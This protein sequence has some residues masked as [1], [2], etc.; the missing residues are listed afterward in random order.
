M[1]MKTGLVVLGVGAAVAGAVWYAF[2][3][4][5]YG[6]L[7]VREGR[8]TS[9]E[10]VPGHYRE[11]EPVDS[12]GRRDLTRP[13]TREWVRP[14]WTVRIAWEG[15]EHVVRTESLYSQVT[16]GSP[17]TLHVRERRWRGR[18]SG[19]SVQTVSPGAPAQAAV[20]AP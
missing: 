16:V 6:P 20:P 15:G 10:H 9:A 17:V 7:E 18:P 1:G 2:T 14:T 19:W 13:P 4:I 3:S 5:G 8:V 11:V 12:E